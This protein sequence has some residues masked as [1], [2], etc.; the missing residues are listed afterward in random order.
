[1]LSIIMLLSQSRDHHFGYDHITMPITSKLC[2]YR[3]FYQYRKTFACCI[4]AYDVTDFKLAVSDM[5]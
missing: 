4:V 3:L 2:I 5:S 1:M